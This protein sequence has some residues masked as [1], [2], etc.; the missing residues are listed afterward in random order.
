MSKDR[1]RQ[2]VFGKLLLQRS[3]ASSPADLHA[4]VGSVSVY[5][6]ESAYNSETYIPEA[7][8]T[9]LARTC[10]TSHE[11]HWSQTRGPPTLWRFVLC[12]IMFF[13]SVNLM[14]GE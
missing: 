11:W 5:P 1:A 4:G 8:S 12:E 14:E 9:T 13:I 3:D 2:R 6:K 7:S 10:K